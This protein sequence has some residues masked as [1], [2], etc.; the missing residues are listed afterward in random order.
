HRTQR[1]DHLEASAPLPVRL[2][3]NA[4][5]QALLVDL[6]R[7]GG[8]DERLPNEAISLVTEQHATVG[9]AAVEL[10]LL[11]QRVLDLEQIGEIRTGGDANVEVDRRVA[12]VQDREVFVEAIA[13]LALTADG[14]IR[15]DI[16]RA[17]SRDEKELRAEILQVVGRQY[18]RTLTI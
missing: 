16:N 9:D 7:R 12:V 18:I 10:T 17:R 2:D 8:G 5:P 4:E 13:D 14:K 11:G 15:V 1:G 3:M 6:D